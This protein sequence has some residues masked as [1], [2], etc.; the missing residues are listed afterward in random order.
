MI[1][2]VLN[3]TRARVLALALVAAG[4]LQPGLSQAQNIN[5]VAGN[6]TQGF[7]GDGGPATSASFA[8]PWGIV[9]DAAGN[10][11]VADLGNRRIRKVTQ[12]GVITTIVGN[13][14][15]GFGGDGGPAT[16]AS[17]SEVFKLAIDANGN[18]YFGD[19][20][21]Q[22]VRKVTPAGTITTIAGTGT[23]GYS[24]DGGPA[25]S[26]Q[27]SSP[28]GVAVDAA[29]N[30]YFSDYYNHAVR[31]ITPG[32]TISTV[33]GTGINGFSGDGG[34]ATSA[35]LSYP[36]SVSVDAGGLLYITDSANNRIRKVEAGVI[37][38]VAGNGIGSF[39][40]DGGP[41]TAASLSDPWDA[42][43][44][45][46]GN[47]YV[48]DAANSR[49]RKVDT[50]GIITTFAGNGV[51][52]FGGDGGPATSASMN[53]PRSIDLTGGTLHIA[54]AGNFR[55][56]EVTL[57][58]TTCAAEGYSGSKLTLCRQ[59]CEVDQSP[60]RLLS[61]IKLYRTAYRM[62]PPCAE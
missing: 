6:G 3:G 54:D 5:T 24:G 9:V 26:A 34:A 20:L 13:G 36:W 1:D 16:A 43:V 58:F 15:N 56:R 19:H 17:I 35:Q 57:P 4:M 62:D 38:T 39:S 11:Y 42:K 45:A 61:L 28:I 48:A 27:L 25:T 37:T 32:G 40:G 46:G 49:I 51:R 21:N 52:A 18:L 22:R 7:S 55:I 8:S 14:S 60:A 29:G 2:Q 50:L 10:T 41:A 53:Y 59:V 31:R 44:D 12:A 33:A 23:Q 47:L 30:V